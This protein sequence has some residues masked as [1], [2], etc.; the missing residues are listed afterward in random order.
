MGLR[1]T[2]S[3]LLLLLSWFCLLLVPLISLP[4]G[5]TLL[6][7]NHVL[8]ALLMAYCADFQYIDGVGW[9]VAANGSQP[10]AGHS[11]SMVIQS[12]DEWSAQAPQLTASEV[13]TLKNVA[14]N[15]VP[16]GALSA[17]DGAVLAWGVVLAWAAGWSARQ[18]IRAF[19]GVSDE[20]D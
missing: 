18:I 2:G 17:E 11:C 9:V 20:A 4:S 16:N 3:P 7:G 1:W 8:L 19:R 15:G 12:V 13:E 14:T 10:P 6:I 5:V